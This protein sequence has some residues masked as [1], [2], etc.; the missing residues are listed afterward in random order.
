MSFLPR[1][2]SYQMSYSHLSSKQMSYSHLSSKQIAGHLLEETSPWEFDR[3]ASVDEKLL[4]NGIERLPRVS[5]KG[6]GEERGKEGMRT[7]WLK[8]GLGEEEEIV[9]TLHLENENGNDGESKGREEKGDGERQ[10][11]GVGEEIDGVIFQEVDSK[12]TVSESLGSRTKKEERKEGEGQRE[13]SDDFDDFDVFDEIGEEGSELSESESAEE[14]EEERDGVGSQR[15]TDDAVEREME[16]KK[17]REEERE[18]ERGEEREEERGE[19]RER[20]EER[21][22]REEKEER[23]ERL[24]RQEEKEISP[25]NHEISTIAKGVHLGIFSLSHNSHSL[26]FKIGSPSGAHQRAPA[27]QWKA[28]RSYYSVHSSLFLSFSLFFILSLAFFLAFSFSAALSVFLIT[29]FPTLL[30]PL[31]SHLPKLR[32]YIRPNR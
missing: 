14:E 9:F 18:G 29:L 27:F 13:S 1:S 23:Q 5:R 22:E 32:S 10:G 16:N 31:S 7:S 17:E 26:N 25:L 11:R 6:R 4:K 19:K 20:E 24:E 28:A 30:S 3:K 12:E 2:I 21:K 8:R 15:V